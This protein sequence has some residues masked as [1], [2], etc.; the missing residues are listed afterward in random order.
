MSGPSTPRRR[1]IAG[2]RRRSGEVVPDAVDRSSELPTTARTPAPPK[3]PK[4]PKPAREPGTAGGTPWPVFAVLTVAAFA[5]VATALWLGLKTWS[6]E[7]IRTQDQV[8]RAEQG[9]SAAAERAAAAVLSYKYD[10]LDADLDGA[11]RFLTPSFKKTFTSTF[12]EFVR[13]FAPK[14]NARVTAKVLAT[15]VVTAS[16]DRAQILA[17]VDQTTVSTANGGRPQVALNRVT[18]TMVKQN[19]TWL[20]DG[21]DAL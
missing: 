2:E 18:F 17:Y 8:E 9:A 6:Y 5:L 3:P 15:A 4:P 16:E 1:R 21:F 7:E 19:G 10:S 11:S 12:D 13:P 14:L 20:V